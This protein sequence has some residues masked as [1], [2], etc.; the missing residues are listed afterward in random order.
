[1]KLLFGKTYVTMQLLL[2][3]AIVSCKKTQKNLDRLDANGKTMGAVQLQGTP[4][5]NLLFESK[6]M[7]E[8]QGNFT[9][10][11]F[12][13][14]DVTGDGRADLIAVTPQFGRAVVWENKGY[15]FGP[16]V[17]W[18]E[19]QG[20]Y[21]GYSFMVSDM[22]GDGKA[23]LIAVTP[24][25]G[26]AVIWR[27]TGGGFPTMTPLMENQGNLS[28]YTF[29]TADM[30][31]D[32]K[33]DL[34]AITPATGRTIIW[35]STGSGIGAAAVWMDNQANFTGY[36]FLA[37]DMT[38]DGKS[39]LV[40]VTPQPCRA[41]VWNSTGSAL[42]TATSWMENQGNY[43]GYNFM[44]ADM[45]GDGRSDLVAVT[46][47]YGRAVMWNNT[48]SSFGTVATM[49]EAQGD[50]SGHTFCLGEFNGT[51]FSGDKR[52]D[53][54]AVKDTT[55]QA[56]LWSYNHSVW[57]ADSTTVRSAELQHLGGQAWNNDDIQQPYL[58][59]M[60]EQNKLLMQLLSFPAVVNGNN[61]SQRVLVSSTDQGTNWSSRTQFPIGK[62]IGLTYAGNGVLYSFE[63]NFKK[64]F[65][66]ST[67]YGA[68]WVSFSNPDTTNIFPWNPLLVSND[69]GIQQITETGYRQYNP[70]F[71][72]NPNYYSLPYVRSSI[73]QGTTWSVPRAIP[74]WKYF[75]EVSLVVAPN[76]DWVAALRKDVDRTQFPHSSYPNNFD[77]YSGLA[78][79]ISKD[80]GAT[81]SNPQVLF[82]YG[83]H[84][85]S[86]LV[87]NDQHTILMTY[88]V[89]VGGARNGIDDNF[90]NSP[91]GYPY[92]GIEA[93]L[94]T[95]NGATWNINKR[96]I[97][98]R[99]KGNLPL[100]NPNYCYRSCQ[101]TSTVQLPDGTLLTAYGT[102]RYRT[103]SG[104]GEWFMDTDVVRWKVW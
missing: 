48:G 54:L 40:A 9:G 51:D 83:R 26:R 61:N 58:V 94:S 98:S 88:A 67:N 3:L 90:S 39:D 29:L 17:A 57:K 11:N 71:D 49:M 85:A 6:I 103:T 66:R 100:T 10:Y 84:H 43:T 75:N 68:S 65:Y 62:P 99:W 96:Y 16:P 21:S 13:T 89:R 77:N 47:Q 12:L 74:N 25:F 19:N 95:D 55:G 86:M 101:S 87:L 50:Y 97:I 36:T 104:N 35:P 32:G 56:T 42:G 63:D 92:Y 27:S 76:G 45:T 33:A 15:I 30:T 22:S 78:V 5:N 41:V 34:L 69:N 20:N 8:R 4:I 44:T 1:M 28:S 23:D 80:K 64:A 82:S 46:P 14:G 72:S 31:G 2:V 73:N 70:P 24:Q 38:G 37:A 60:P 93:I 59:Y 81:W 52:Y 102:G 7:Q 79:S 91:D 18:M 53:L